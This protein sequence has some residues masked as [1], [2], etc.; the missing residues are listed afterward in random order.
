MKPILIPIICAV[1]MPSVASGADYLSR[2]GWK[3]YTSSECEQ[4]QDIAGLKGL[5]DGNTATCWHSNYHAESGTPERSNPHWVMID[6]GTDTSLAYG[7]SYLPRQNYG[8]NPATAC[9]EYAIYFAD[10]TFASTSS[11][12][13]EQIVSELGQP[14]MK[15]SW[16]GDSSE[17]IVLF[18]KPNSA[19]YI[20]FVNIKSNGSNSAAC[21]EM[22]LMSK[23]GGSGLTPGG[24]PYNAISI[25]TPEGDTHRIAI[26]GQNLAFSIAGGN[27]RM[28][29]S[30]ITVEYAMDEVKYFQP[31]NYEFGNEEFY[32]GPKRDIYEFP[33]E[34]A[35]DVTALTLEEGQSFKLTATLTNAP[36]GAEVV[37]ETSDMSVVKVDSKGNLTAMAPGEA[38][39]SARYEDV[40]AECQVTVTA[41]PVVP[42]EISLNTVSLT[43][44][45]GKTFRLTASVLNTASEVVW[46]SSDK[47]V[48]S[49]DSKG[50]VTAVKPGVA[51][52]KAT[53]DGAVAECEVT[54]TAKTEVGIDAV[55]S[56][57]LTLKLEGETLIIGGINRGNEAVLHSL[58]GVRLRSGVVD[59][60]GVAEISVAGLPRAAYL[61]SVSGLTLKIT[62]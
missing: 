23:A 53:C 41:K 38:T 26:D 60:T 3:W 9:T 12:S 56:S 49:V 54:V 34:I 61:L 45:E 18:E 58:G 19:R 24:S 22:N 55:Q 7:L 2:S 30:S 47:A 13:W 32:N 37:W 1:L 33:V 35:L 11:S 27:I 39:I 36:E 14:D 25:V 50:L 51:V 48:A 44:E 20:L 6:R 42:V 5:Y 46:S 52:I 10:R 57:A 28:G 31:D 59:S 8:E 4:E 43:L 29:N 40:I 62:I 16:A 15:G 21:A 17:K